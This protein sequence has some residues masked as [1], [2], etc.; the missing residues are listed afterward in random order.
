MRVENQQSMNALRD[1]I[2]AWCK[3]YLYIGLH[4]ALKI[5]A[6]I[7]LK[8]FHSKIWKIFHFFVNLNPNIRSFC[9]FYAFSQKY[10]KWLQIGYRKI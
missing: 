7:F 1:P 10:L 8:H 9:D 6:K 3:T 5:V 4:H 2:S